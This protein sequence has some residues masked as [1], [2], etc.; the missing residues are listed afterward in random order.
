MDAKKRDVETFIKARVIVIKGSIY[1]R[2]AR[3]VVSGVLLGNKVPTPPVY[4]EF[5]SPAEDARSI[6]SR[7]AA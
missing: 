7:G 3:D 5:P 2:R 1:C 4:L 6:E